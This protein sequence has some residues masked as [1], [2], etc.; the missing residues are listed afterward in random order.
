MIPPLDESAKN[1]PKRNLIHSVFFHDE[2]LVRVD[3]L[4]TF[5]LLKIFHSIDGAFRGASV[6]PITFLFYAVSALAGV[7]FAKKR[8]SQY[9]SMDG[10][11]VVEIAMIYLFYYLLNGIVTRSI[12][13]Y[14]ISFNGIFLCYVISFKVVISLAYVYRS[15][16]KKFNSEEDK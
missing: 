14:S 11:L 2:V 13:D 10:F 15:Y 16:V 12:N 8:V 6:G 5:I 4:I 1:E 7:Y 9:L 3:M